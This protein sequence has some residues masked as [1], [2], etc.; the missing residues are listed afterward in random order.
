MGRRESNF[1]LTVEH[2]KLA[3]ISEEF[4][5]A[6]VNALMRNVVIESEDDV[7]EFCAILKKYRPEVEKQFFAN[8][9]TA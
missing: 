8:I 5:D 4:S 9:K 3:C 2:F 7:R 1:T 6:D